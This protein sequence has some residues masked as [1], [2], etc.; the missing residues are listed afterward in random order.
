MIKWSSRNEGFED[1]IR[2]GRP[3]VLNE[4]AKK[5]LKKAKYTRGNSTR[6]L[7]QQLA[8]KGLVGGKNT[9]W[10]FMKS[11][12]WRPLR[13]QKKPLFTAKQRAARLK[14]AKQYKNLTT[15]ERDD[16][17]FSDECP[18]CLFQLPN[19]KNDI[20]WGSQES[21][22][23]P[24]YQV[25]KSSKWIIWGGMRGRGLTELHFIP[26][27]QTLTA[28]YYYINK[29]EKEVK[30]LLRRKN[31]NEAIDKRKLFSSNRHMTFVQDGAPS[32]AAKATQAWCK[33]NLP[34]FIEKAGW[35]PNSP[36]IN[37]VENR[38]SIMHEVLYKDPTPKT[39]KDLKRRL[40]QAGRISRSPRKMTYPTRCRNG[41]RM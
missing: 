22:M 29:L 35:P 38:W 28:D 41:Y 13:R 21:Q 1:K 24:A 31:V 34:N 9:V 37:P 39:M 18:K 7:S 30:P 23:P 33:R 5:V 27:G 36:D 10:R 3:K 25:K 19:P 12:G 17:L 40:Q 2:T 16:F 20:V 11:K 6:Q 32:H 15:E 26:Q 4:A 8:S 14:F